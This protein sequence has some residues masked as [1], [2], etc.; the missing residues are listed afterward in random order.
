MV[1]VLTSA[2]VLIATR[3]LAGARPHLAAVAG[4]VHHED[5]WQL[6]C[7]ELTGLDVRLDGW[8]IRGRWFGV[9]VGATPR[10]GEVARGE[11]IPWRVIAAQIAPRE[12]RGPR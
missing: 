10:T 6:C 1:S 12:R 2:E 11:T 3:R 5:M 7:D 9:V 4:I 8:D